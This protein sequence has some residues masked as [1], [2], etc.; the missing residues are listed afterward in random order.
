MSSTDVSTGPTG[1]AWKIPVIALSYLVAETISGGIITALGMT[2]PSVP[3]EMTST[4]VQVG[5]AIGSILMAGCLAWLAVGL[6]GGTALR[7]IVLAAFGA[8]LTTH[9]ALLRSVCRP[10]ADGRISGGP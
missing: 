7:W 6:K 10:A 8:G 1:M 5:N 3:Q 4:A 9:A 2:W